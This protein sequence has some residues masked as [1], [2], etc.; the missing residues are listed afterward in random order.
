MAQKYKD[1]FTIKE[2]SLLLQNTSVH[3]RI[4]QAEDATFHAFKDGFDN[5]KLIFTNY[6]TVIRKF[7]A[8]VLTL[9]VIHIVL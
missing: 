9:G 6:L 5:E 7:R 8:M 4:K 2:N 3:E 1:D